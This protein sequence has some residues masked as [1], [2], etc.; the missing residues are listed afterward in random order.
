[1]KNFLPIGSVVLLKTGEKKLMIC[2]RVQS[3]VATGKVYDYSACLYPEG[4]INSN[5]LILFNNENID[6][7]FFIGFQD[8]EE[9]Q[10]R[11]YIIK[12][13]SEEQAE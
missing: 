4:L 5:E 2:G 9:F 11:K 10:F 7:V 1:M 8:T 12:A 3:D 13:V 6:R